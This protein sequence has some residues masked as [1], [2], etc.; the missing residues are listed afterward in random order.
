MCWNRW[1]VAS[2]LLV[3][4][5]LLWCAALQSAS[6]QPVST[7]E[8]STA[9]S[10]FGITR[11]QSGQHAYNL[12]TNLLLY[13]DTT[14]KLSLDD[15]LANPLLPRFQHYTQPALNIGYSNS[16]Y[17]IKMVFVNDIPEKEGTDWLLEFNNPNIGF[18][19]FFVQDPTGHFQT[20]TTG[21]YLPFVQRPTQHRHVI[22]PFASLPV[23]YGK[24][25]VCY[26]RIC[27]GEPIRL[28]PTIWRTAQFYEY[29]SARTLVLGLYYGILMIVALYNLMLF[30]IVRERSYL[31]A[32][33]FMLIAWLIQFTNDGLAYQYLWSRANVWNQEGR[34]LLNGAVFVFLTLFARNFLQTANS[35]PRSDAILQ[36]FTIASV[37]LV[38]LKFLVYIH[39]AGY[40]HTWQ[41]DTLFFIAVVALPSFYLVRQARREQWNKALR[42]AMMISSVF[43]IAGFTTNKFVEH[44]LS[45]FDRI[46]NALIPTGSVVVMTLVA[47][48]QTRRG[49]RTARVFL[50][51]AWTLSA[52][53][54]VEELLHI[55]VLPSNILTESFMK[56][57]TVMMA[58]LFSLPLGDRIRSLRQRTEELELTSLAAQKA[59]A[60]ARLE[61]LQAKINP[62]FLFN[63]LNSIASL[64]SIDA[65]KAEQAVVRLSK[66]F[67]YTLHRSGASAK[68]T[69]T[70][71]E[72]IDVVRM[73]LE[74]EHLRLAERLRTTIDVQGDA[75]TVLLPALTLQPL[76]EN[77]VKYAVAPR[78][79]GGTIVITAIVDERSCRIVIRDDGAGLTGRASD[80]GHGLQSVQ[81]R[82][83]LMFGE[84]CSFELRDHDG[85]EIVITLHSA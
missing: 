59:A 67:R 39:N 62:H 61:A 12:T 31:F 23:Q 76:V 1:N 80:S 21:T 49:N 26:A 3:I 7:S 27:S 81:E 66:L 42:A 28:A 16:S 54:L 15:I 29:D 38:A 79:A 6:A 63:T 41:A 44:G 56:S 78:A 82:L 77:S 52:A 72:E 74:L 20:I 25:F 40:V 85:V 70:L 24:P 35:M 83:A 30:L 5:I 48:M 69:A 68:N 58:I 17:W 9:D 75:K 14:N 34:G 64:I 8:L 19:E 47:L 37:Q 4:T 50:A 10:T 32:S 53:I 43:W 36:I 13:E 65:A 18:L 46:M 73:Y 11:L 33:L 71:A 51:A 22:I 55:G 84:R 45:T 2:I 57:G 60:E